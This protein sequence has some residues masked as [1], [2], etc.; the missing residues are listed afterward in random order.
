MQKQKYEVVKNK[1]DEIFPSNT[2]KIPLLRSS[3]RLIS[4]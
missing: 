2:E 4:G 1:T 3:A